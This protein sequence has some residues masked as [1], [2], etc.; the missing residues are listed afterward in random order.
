MNGHKNHDT[1]AP[2]LLHLQEFRFVTEQL[3]ACVNTFE[4]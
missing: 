2:M 1:F 4:T 3:C